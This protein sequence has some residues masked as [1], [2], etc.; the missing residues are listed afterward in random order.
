MLI[1]RVLDFGL[2]PFQIRR[3]RFE[4]GIASFADP[5]YARLGANDAEGS[6]FHV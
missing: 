5:E 6:I 2:P 3:V 4:P 1:E